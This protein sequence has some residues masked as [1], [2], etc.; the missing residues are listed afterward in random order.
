MRNFF[1]TLR[2]L[3]CTT[4]PNSDLFWDSNLGH[5]NQLEQTINHLQARR[6]STSPAPGLCTDTQPP[7]CRPSPTQKHAM[8]W[9]KTMSHRILPESPQTKSALPLRRNGRN[10]LACNAYAKHRSFRSLDLQH[11]VDLPNTYRFI[12]SYTHVQTLLV[13]LLRCWEMLS[14]KRMLLEISCMIA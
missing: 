10:C 14:R 12:A 1:P 2:P 9:R 11:A 3:K 5:P 6:C 13:C 4:L 8:K 7:S